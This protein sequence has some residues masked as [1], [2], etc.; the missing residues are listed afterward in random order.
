MVFEINIDVYLFKDSV[1][2]TVWSLWNV[3][4][5]LWIQRAG[6]EKQTDSNKMWRDFAN[7]TYLNNDLI[8]QGT[9]KAFFNC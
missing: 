5:F 7:V 9:N 2:P 6:I 1:F 8:L 3:E 4:N